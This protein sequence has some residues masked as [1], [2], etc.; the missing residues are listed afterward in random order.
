[1]MGRKRLRA[2]TLPGRQP[3]YDMRPNYIGGQPCNS[4]AIEVDD[5]IQHGGKIMVY[6]SL[7]AD[8][9]ARMQ[10]R[11]QI[12]EAQYAAGRYWQR[13]YETA[14]ISGARAIDTT[15]EAVDGGQIARAGVS[16]AQAQAFKTLARSARIVGMIGESVL[17]DV[18]GK[19]MDFPHV[20]AA[21]GTV[22]ERDTRYYARLFRECLETLAGEF[23]FT[24]RRTR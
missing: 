7:R 1:M 9:L 17:I 5:P 23:G 16:D 12:D 24:N 4:A 20:A 10:D 3:S 6:R 8:P 14:E 15:R 18:L 11:R 22:Q 2:V 13:A 21:R 19:G